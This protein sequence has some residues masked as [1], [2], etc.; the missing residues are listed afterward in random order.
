MKKKVVLGFSGGLDTCF[1]TEYLKNEGYDVITVTVDTGGFSEKELIEIEK[2][3]KQLGA[4][5]HY[6][7]NVRDEFY[8]E[9]LSYLIKANGLYEENYPLMT[10]DRYIIAKKLIEIAKTENT[11]I[12][13]HGSTGQGNDQVRFDAAVISLNPEIKILAPVRTLSI[14][15]KKE[16]EYLE[17]TGFNIDSAYKKYTINQNL[18]GYTVSGSEIDDYKE[19]SEETI[20]L[21]KNTAKGPVY[22][23]LEF[24]TGEIK[25]IDGQLILGSEVLIK[26]NLIAGSHGYGRK[27]VVN[28]TIIGIK[29]RIVF[30]SPGILALIEAHKAME[31]AVLTKEQYDFKKIVEQKW[32]NLAYNGKYFDP[33]L[34][35]LNKFLDENQKNVTGKVTLKFS[36]GKCDAV[37]VESPYLLEAKEIASYVN[38]STWTEDEAVGFIKLYSLQ[39]KIYA[40]K[41]G[42]IN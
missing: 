7:L 12:V 10:I 38:S 15:R 16:Q 3:S 19:P 30:E 27:V 31:K 11:D 41:N 34:K 42:K 22:V 39:Q 8:N 5:K 36:D 25:K 4:I 26:L 14:S 13:S 6:S 35:D 2:K 32:A 28:N 37:E 23:T 21:T 9:F 24:L 1:C 18:L 17:N 20:I 29:G 33:L 40:M